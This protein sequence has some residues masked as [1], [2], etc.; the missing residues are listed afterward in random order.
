MLFR[1]RHALQEEHACS[2]GKAYLKSVLIAEER[3]LQVCGL[4]L[5][6]YAALRY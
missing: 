4:T 1:Y 3:S 5:L 2:S 6:V